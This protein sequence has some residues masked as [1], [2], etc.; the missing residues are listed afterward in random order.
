MKT[1]HK[2]ESFESLPQARGWACFNKQ[3]FS[4]KAAPTVLITPFGLLRRL[5][6]L[7]L[8]KRITRKAQGA[9]NWQPKGHLQEVLRARLTL[10]Y[11]GICMAKRATVIQ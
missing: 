5:P 11:L 7:A 8:A 3:S 2:C 9:V 4:A 10:G 6:P 1:K